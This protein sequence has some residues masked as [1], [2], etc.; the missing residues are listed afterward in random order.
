MNGGAAVMWLFFLAAPWTCAGQARDATP[1]KTA[2]GWLDLA[3]AQAKQGN[4]EAALEAARK[5]EA[6]G[7]E[8][9]AILQ[10]L[11]NF[12][13]TA[14]ADPAKAAALGYRYAERMPEDRTAWRRLAQFCLSTGQSE[15][16]IEAAKKGS[17]NDNSAE[18][19]GILGT[20][21]QQIQDW[22]HAETE[23]TEALRLAPY[24]EA[25]HFQLAQL[26]LLQQDFVS[27]VRV[28]ENARKIFDKSAQIELAMGVAWYGQREFPKA[29]DQFLK[30]I[31][32]APDVP[33]PYAFLG[34]IL[35]HAGD[36][37]PEVAARFAEYV[38][39]H[40]QD[41]LGHVLR[42]KAIIIQ[43]PPSGYPEEAQR[44]LGLLEQ[45]LKLKEDDAEAHL[46][47]GTLLERKGDFA[48]AAAHLERS[49]ALNAKD[50]APHYRLAR[51]YARL[52]RPEDSRRERE[53]HEKLSNEENPFDRGIQPGRSPAP[54]RVK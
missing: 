16:A 18:L 38:A 47:M 33:Q 51:V 3:Q 48:A 26:Y 31:R 25:R 10:A 20:A 36:R 6:L 44:A 53:L 19:H 12:Y 45:A 50:P 17:K 49:I 21:Y 32:L 27:A 28:L 37:M 46:L 54:P 11:A 1:P 35:E 14:G 30:T 9:P 34:R 7:G 4:R 8:D 43:L 22:K 42:A 5:A 39:R 41:P 2:S 23:L 40:P 15:R 24:D 29:V 13:A 52:G